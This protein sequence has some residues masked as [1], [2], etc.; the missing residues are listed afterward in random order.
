M[1]DSHILVI[2][3]DKEA[4]ALI[5]VRLKRHGFQVSVVNIPEEAIEFLKKDV[6]DLVILDLVMPGIDG[7]EILRKIRLDETTKAVPV[8]VLTAKSDQSDRVN[9]F[10]M[11]AQDYITKPYEPEEFLARIKAALRR[12]NHEVV[13]K[14]IKNVLITGGAGFIGSA[15]ARRLLA[16]EYKITVID[17]F[18]TGSRENI[19]DMLNN[20]N[21]NLIVGSITDETILSKA[22]EESD[23]IYHLAATVG[24]KNVIEKPLDTVIYDTIGTSII[25]KYASSKGVKVVLTSTS[26]VYGKSN[27]YPF[28]EDDDVV[29]G[30]P[31]VNRWSYA[32]SKL[33]DEFFAIG[34]YRERG[35][36]VVIVR[37]F[38]IVGPRQVGRYGMVIPRFFKSALQNQP[39]Y[40]YGNGKQSRCFTYIDDAINIILK[41]AQNQQAVGQ[42]INLGSNNLI[43]IKD[44]ACEIKRITKSSSKIVF[45][46]YQKYYGNR[47]EDI[48]KRIPDL[49]KLK[50][51]SGVTPET[52]IPQILKKMKDYFEENP[53]ELDRI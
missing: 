28:K 21:F 29:I 33:L 16:E 38:N 10:N 45:E 23:L 44:L 22:I 39:I 47:F 32:C 36:P 6:P 43:S 14:K 34:Y 52:T 41:L 26:E 5:S 11:G 49:T 3:D 42:V 2:D 25:L 7:Y 13:T 53:K 9:A 20:K 31:D 18:S 4:T 37:F 8:I 19:Q 1:N 48:K 27:K 15:L 30:P 46:P 17:D 51:I 12:V 50:K 40:V 24:V 35:L